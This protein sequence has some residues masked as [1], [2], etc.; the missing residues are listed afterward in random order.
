MT[1]HSDYHLTDAANYETAPRLIMNYGRAG[2]A[3]VE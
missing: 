1:I 2:Q 3:G